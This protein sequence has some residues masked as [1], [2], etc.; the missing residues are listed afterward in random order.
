ML[1]TWASSWCTVQSGQAGTMR[2]RSSSD[3]V[4]STEMMRERVRAYAGNRFSAT[5]AL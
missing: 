2:V 1:T 4:S 5:W 3:V